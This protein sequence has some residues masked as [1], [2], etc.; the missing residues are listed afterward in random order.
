MSPIKPLFRLIRPMRLL[1]TLFRFNGW[2]VLLK[3]LFAGILRRRVELMVNFYG[4]RVKIRTD[5]PDLIVAHSSLGHEFSTLSMVYPRDISGLIIDAG[6]YIGTAAI[7]F[8]RMYPRATVVTIEPSSANFRLLTENIKAHPNIIPINAALVPSGSGSHILLHD[9][10]E[11]EWS[12][13]VIAGKDPVSKRMPKGYEEAK[14]VTVADILARTD[15]TR[16][17][18]FKMDIE[19]GELPILREDRNWLSDTDILI[20]ELHER[21]VKGCEPAFFEASADRLVIKNFG[22]KFIS[23]GRSFFEIAAVNPPKTR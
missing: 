5:S 17:L 16:V 8:A 23:I 10:A 18:I 22:E 11:G 9:S 2:F 20:A 15:N 21:V 19:G 14:T 1:Y 4:V 12:F 3:V 13:S 6:G 7:A